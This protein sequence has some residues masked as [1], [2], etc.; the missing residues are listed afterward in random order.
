MCEISHGI[1]SIH[2]CAADKKVNDDLSV[3]ISFNTRD[4]VL[5]YSGH[6]CQCSPR[7]MRRRLNLNEIIRRR[8]CAIDRKAL[9]TMYYLA[10]RRSNRLGGAVKARYWSSG[11]QAGGIAPNWHRCSRLTSSGFF[12]NVRIYYREDDMLHTWQDRQQFAVGSL[13]AKELGF[14]QNEVGSSDYN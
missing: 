6:S 4:I 1:A 11:N 10:N 3:C 5:E 12:K 2:L 7:W 8:Q 13:S 9:A 14:L